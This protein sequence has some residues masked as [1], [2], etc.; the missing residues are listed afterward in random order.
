MNHCKNAL[1]MY[2]VDMKLIIDA[3]WIGLGVQY[4]T[5]NLE[6]PGLSDSWQDRAKP[7]ENHENVGIRGKL[8]VSSLSGIANDKKFLEPSI[9]SWA[10]CVSAVQMINIFSW[11]K[12]KSVLVLH[13]EELRIEHRIDKVEKDTRL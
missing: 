5:T 12:F 6:P 7:F 13:G 4:P 8:W 1:G 10:V 11:E 9:S 2:H 3:M